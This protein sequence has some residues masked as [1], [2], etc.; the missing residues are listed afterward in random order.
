MVSF[1]EASLAQL[2]IHRV[3]NK[4]Q[5]EFYVL[6]D[7]SL[8]IE[9]EFLS[10]LLMQYYLKPFEKVNEVY[11]FLHSSDLNLNE[12]FHFSTEVFKE[13]GR[14]HEVSQQITKYLFDLTNHP[15]IKSGELYVAYFNNV[16]IEGELLDAIGIF[17]SETKETYLKV[18]PEDSGFNLGY[19]QEGINIQKLDKGCLI[20]NTDKEEGFKVLVV[21][22]TNKSGEA[23]Y[24]KDEFLKL[25]IRNDNYN[26]TSNTLNVYKSFVTNKLEED[27]EMT[28]AD[29][30][31]L[32]NRSMKYFKEKESF[33]MDE[34]SNEVIGNP[35][36][37]ES[38]KSFKQN[39]EKE[40]DTEIADSFDISTPA[41][42]KQAK[43]FKSVLKLDKNFHIYI[44]GNKE[45]IEK[46]FDDSKAMNY[47]KV[48]FKEEE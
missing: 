34:F 14:F 8:Q 4:L 17:K 36:A 22:Q 29:K 2:S 38:F 41:V 44:H 31:D 18:Y 1:F 20:F 25:K 19:E 37:I 7:A 6:S 27:F 47:Y 45:L 10:N 15:K 12:L 3:G 32:L 5:D 35:K 42:K 30:I 9:D 28:K 26:Q 40:F 48:Y 43:V 11:R 33:E 46:G 23:V 24:W 21:D 13:K 16:Q 39:Y